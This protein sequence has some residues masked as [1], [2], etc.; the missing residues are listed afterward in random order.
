MR[1]YVICPGDNAVNAPVSA[2]SENS[3]FYKLISTSTSSSSDSSDSDPANVFKASD[4]TNKHGSATAQGDVSVVR[5]GDKA[6]KVYA[7]SYLD[8]GLQAAQK[9]FSRRNL[10]HIEAE[11]NP[12]YSPGSRHSAVGEFKNCVALMPSLL[13]RAD[14]NLGAETAGE[15]SCPYPS[16]GMGQVY[17]P[18][19]PE[20]MTF[21]ALENFYY[22]F[23]IIES[24]NNGLDSMK[25]GKALVKGLNTAGK[26]DCAL[27]VGEVAGLPQWKAEQACFTSSFVPFVVDQ[28]GFSSRLDTLVPTQ[29]I[30]GE[31]VDWALGSAIRILES[32]RRQIRA[33]GWISQASF[34]ATILFYIL[35]G[36]GV[37]WLLTQWTGMSNKPGHMNLGAA[38]V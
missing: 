11:G 19:L 29:T 18:T 28:L 17:Q 33:L 30:N 27:Q 12:C 20:E 23:E 8:L 3:Q 38:K 22:A 2:G 6:F 16:C 21:F 4:V 13:D 7:H 34:R 32:E 36:G 25:T 35:V 24:Y 14:S 37:L 1:I 9:R 15:D 26:V 31:G 5:L 10:E